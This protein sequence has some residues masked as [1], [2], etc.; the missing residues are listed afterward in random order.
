MEH[1]VTCMDVVHWSNLNN[2]SKNTEM[3]N[4]TL[5]ITLRFYCHYKTL[6]LNSCNLWKKPRAATPTIKNPQPF[7]TSHPCS[8]AVTETLTD[9]L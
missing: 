5:T 4:L 7:S 6:M 9:R 8:D 1:L 2:E 3:H